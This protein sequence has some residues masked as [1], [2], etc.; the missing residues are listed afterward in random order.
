MHIIGFTIKQADLVVGNSPIREQA[1]SAAKTRAQQ[2]GIPVSVIA[3]LDTGADREVIFYPDGTNE[4]IWAIDQGRRIQP[5]VG[6]VYTNRGG[7]RFRCIAP[8]DNGP[9]FWNAAGG[10]SNASGVSR[11]SKA[12][13]H[14]WPRALSSTSTE[15][16]SGTTAPT[17]A[18]SRYNPSEEDIRLRHQA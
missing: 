16:L 11:T 5:V 4:R 7:G 17:G 10:C 6:A 15:A 8:A 3:H 14:S 12:D 13:G 18:S 2:T 1:V 9:M